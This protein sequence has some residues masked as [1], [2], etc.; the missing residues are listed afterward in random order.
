MTPDLMRPANDLGQPV[1]FTLSRD[2]DL[3]SAHG[4]FHL[5]AGEAPPEV[6]A[7]T[8]TDPDWWNDPKPPWTQPTLTPEESED[9]DRAARAEMAQQGSLVGQLAGWTHHAYN[10]ALQNVEDLDELVYRTLVS[11]HP[12]AELAAQRSAS[13]LTKTSELLEAYAQADASV[14]NERGASLQRVQARLAAEAAAIASK[15]AKP[16]ARTHA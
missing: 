7:R 14:G 15:S 10:E 13:V 4:Q 8:L 2:V 3:S 1:E 9:A 6:L 16:G 11:L 5:D 12:P